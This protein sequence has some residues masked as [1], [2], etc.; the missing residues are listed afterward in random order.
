MLAAVLTLIKPFM[1]WS[2]KT[3][4]YSKL[5][6]GHAKIAHAFRMLIDDIRYTQQWTDDLERRFSDARGTFG[7]LETLDDPKPSAKLTKRFQA[8]VNHEVPPSS[9][10]MP[11]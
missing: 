10:W 1:G 8:E 4:D 2:K 5:F 6:T 3:E 9:L 11:A 7:E